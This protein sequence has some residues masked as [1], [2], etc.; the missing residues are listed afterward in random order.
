MSN[1]KNPFAAIGDA[2][3]SASTPPQEQTE[4]QSTPTPEAQPQT[5]KKTSSKSGGKRSDP[6][7]RQTTIYIDKNLHR[8]FLRK[9]E[10]SGFEGDFSDWVEKKMRAEV[11]E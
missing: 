5:V 9:L 2:A 10:D 11:Q 7:Y 1:K 4:I 3:R 6:N 8:Q